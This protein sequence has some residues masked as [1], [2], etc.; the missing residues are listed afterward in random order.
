M[1]SSFLRAKSTEK[2][3][4]VC[5]ARFFGWLSLVPC[6]AIIFQDPLAR[7]RLNA[8]THKW[9][10][11]KA[12]ERVVRLLLKVLACRASHVVSTVA[13]SWSFALYAQG[14][15]MVVIDAPLLLE[16][17]LQ[18]LMSS[19]VVVSAVTPTRTCTCS[20]FAYHSNTCET[21]LRVVGGWGTT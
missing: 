11:L 8:A 13:V 19:I 5:L 20:C 7:R 21:A 6:L 18:K 2:S 14:K 12:F 16:S 15:P 10:T 17:N 9:I 3:L 1:T 4:A